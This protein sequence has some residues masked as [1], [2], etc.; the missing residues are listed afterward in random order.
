MLG[1]ILVAFKKRRREHCGRA[2]TRMSGRPPPERTLLPECCPK[3]P[4]ND[5][6]HKKGPKRGRELDPRQ[7]QAKPE[8]IRI[9]SN[10]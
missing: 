1:I 6:V 7:A 4:K 10:T 8:P 2:E 9:R 5:S 3:P